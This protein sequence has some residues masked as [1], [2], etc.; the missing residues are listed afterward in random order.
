[1]IPYGG[2]DNS[3]FCH[4]SFLDRRHIQFLDLLS[5]FLNSWDEEMYL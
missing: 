2:H 3:R 4:T 5:Q 1:M